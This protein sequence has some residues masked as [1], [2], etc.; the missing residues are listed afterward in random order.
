M[1]AI[2]PQQMIAAN[3]PN[4]V[5]LLSMI[6]ARI[7]SLETDDGLDTGLIDHY[8]YAIEKVKADFQACGYP[9]TDYYDQEENQLSRTVIVD[10]I[11]HPVYGKIKNEILYLSDDDEIYIDDLKAFCADLKEDIELAQSNEDVVG[12]HLANLAYSTEIRRRIAAKVWVV[13]LTWPALRVLGAVERLEDHRKLTLNADLNELGAMDRDALRARFS[14]EHLLN[15]VFALR[16]KLGKVTCVID[17]K[18]PYKRIAFFSH[19]GIIN[20]NWHSEEA[21]SSNGHIRTKTMPQ[22]FATSLAGRP[23]DE[24]IDHPLG[25]NLD[26]KVIDAANND[27]STNIRTDEKEEFNLIVLERPLS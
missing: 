2:T 8:S 19:A 13:T 20:V 21:Q 9:V 16:N 27:I 6:E 23:L 1:H 22:S 3:L 7:V 17:D 25:R 26:L 10:E 11:D 5:K 4:A 15:Q 14:D 24:V 12:R 18:E